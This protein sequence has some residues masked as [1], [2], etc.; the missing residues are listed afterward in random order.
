MNSTT[1]ATHFPVETTDYQQIKSGTN[2][3]QL[4]KTKIYDEKDVN[5]NLRYHT[6][7]YA[8]ESTE[9]KDSTNNNSNVWVTSVVISLGLFILVCVICILRVFFYRKKALQPTKKTS[10]L[11]GDK[12]KKLTPS[13]E[14]Q[15]KTEAM[16]NGH[17]SCNRSSDE[18]AHASGEL[19]PFIGKNEQYKL[20][21]I[22]KESQQHQAVFEDWEQI[23][24][25]CIQTK[26]CTKVESLIQ[27]ENLVIVVGHSGSGKSA[28]IQHIALK[29]RRQGW[30]VKKAN[31]VKDVIDDFKSNNV[32]KN[33][34]LVVLN[35]PI[36]KETFDEQEHKSWKKLEGDLIACLKKF[37]LL[38]SCRKCV[39]SDER[40]MGLFK[41]ESNIVDID[42]DDCKLS[43]DEKQK[44]WNKYKFD[45]SS[46]KIDFAE[47]IKID[48]NFSLLCNLF[49]SDEKKQKKRIT[50]F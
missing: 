15:D 22:T 40:A 39:Q 1:T 31:E 10:G 19:K 48:E 45:N 30:V 47:I 50:I 5:I 8:E 3:T 4:D 26:A 29:Y 13:N 17:A 34:T 24:S 2:S 35:D 46:F 37:K 9:Y 23:N 25:K 49:F 33:Q 12:Y 16:E 32:L 6:A 38:L 43:D 11:E 18:D 14:R 44:N 42:A 27:K 21:S 41:D 28:I 7:E 36:K 20:S